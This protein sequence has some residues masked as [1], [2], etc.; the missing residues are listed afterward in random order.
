MVG[1]KNSEVSM[2]AKGVIQMAGFGSVKDPRPMSE[3]ER[4]FVKYLLCREYNYWVEIVNAN[5]SLPVKKMKLPR[6]AWWE[7]I[8]GRMDSLQKAIHNV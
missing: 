4:A 6:D 7:G 8:H 3:E 2:A 5:S 1:R